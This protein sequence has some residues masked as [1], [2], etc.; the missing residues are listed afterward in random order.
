MKTGLYLRV[1]LYFL[2]YLVTRDPHADKKRSVFSEVLRD[3]RE[4]PA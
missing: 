3:W 2:R 1:A 4:G